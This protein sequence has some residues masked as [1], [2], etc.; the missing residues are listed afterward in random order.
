MNH[1]EVT[2]ECA[3]ERQREILLAEL[4]DLP[5]ESFCEEENCL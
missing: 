3:D 5:F 2:V 1:I 4:A